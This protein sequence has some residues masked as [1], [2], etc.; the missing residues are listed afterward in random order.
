MIGGFAVGVALLLTL[1][2]VSQRA[3]RSD[4]EVPI[5][6]LLLVAVDLLIDGVLVGVGA[7]LGEGQGRILTI[8]LTL[9]VLFLALALVISFRERGATRS[10]AIALT[11]ATS[12]TMAAGAIG[13]AAVLGGASHDVLAAV[14]AFGAAAL[15]Y[16]VTEELLVEAHENAETWFLTA[17]FFVGFLAVF[18]L[19]S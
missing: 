8:A 4:R 9:E 5:G 18:V 10:K 2:V 7:A 6:L 1:R 14:L 13:G 12:L 3:E 16:L 15:M 11:W 17:L 19:E